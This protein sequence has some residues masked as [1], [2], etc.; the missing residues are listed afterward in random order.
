MTQ[1]RPR[2]STGTGR[3]VAQV[4]GMPVSLALTERCD[5]CLRIGGPSKGADEEADR[6]LAAGRPVFSSLAELVASTWEYGHE[7]DPAPKEPRRVAWRASARK[8]GPIKPR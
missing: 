8:R 5:A 1:E 3:Y 4:M 7:S 6:F 2:D